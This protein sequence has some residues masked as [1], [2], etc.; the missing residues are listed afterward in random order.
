MIYKETYDT[1]TGLLSVT[2]ANGAITQVGLQENGDVNYVKDP[3][4]N[5]NNA[6]F[7]DKKLTSIIYPDGTTE[8]FSYDSNGY[9]MSFTNRAKE[10]VSYIKN[11]QGQLLRKDIHGDSTFYNYNENGLLTEAWN[12]KSRVK[13]SYNAENRPLSVEYD[14]QRK[15]H[16][17]YDAMGRRVG[18]SDNN[19]YNISY[20]YDNIGRLVSVNR[21]K[22]DVKNLLKI[23][24]DLR[25][26]IRTRTTGDGCYGN[27]TFD[28]KNSQ[29]EQLANI[30]KSG[31]ILEKFD[32]QY[33]RKGRKKRIRTTSGTS[34]ISYDLM[35][36][37]TSVKYPSGKTS[38][39]SYDDNQNRLK[40]V[41][42]G[43]ET[44]YVSNKLNQYQ[45]VGS[46]Q[47]FTYDQN[48]NTVTIEDTKTKSE[49]RY[50]YTPEGKII[51][52]SSNSDDYCA[53]SYDALG[54]LRKATCASGETEFLIDPFGLF[55]AE[56]ISEVRKHMLFYKFLFFRVCFVLEFLN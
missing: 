22:L 36:Q 33:D 6:T 12:N 52:T 43:V 54:N 55:G 3:M 30:D 2:D 34:D 40:V 14:R 4:G 38:Q 44:G 24:Y 9:V 42:Y 7:K 23:S 45:T 19:G 15:L 21:N 27:F 11:Q 18:L 32:F 28:S 51:G 47:R 35:S 31:N 46:T 25:G 5:Y 41:E 16:Y 37:I 20:T 56:I 48:G 17:T 13:I 10:K 26:L 53:Y 29:I 39:I 49:E 8:N 50:K 1:S